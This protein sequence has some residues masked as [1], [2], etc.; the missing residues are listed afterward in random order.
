[1][2]ALMSPKLTK[3]ISMSYLNVDTTDDA[4]NDS[5][6]TTMSAVNDALEHAYREGIRIAMIIVN[7]KLDEIAFERGITID[8]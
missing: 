8:E 6:T 1:M 5:I 4:T 2:Q 3:A 7:G